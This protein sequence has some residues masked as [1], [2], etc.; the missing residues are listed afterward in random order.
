[1]G[2]RTKD[3]EL[4][5]G[6]TLSSSALEEL[7]RTFRGQLVTPADAEYDASRRVRNAMVDRHPALIA[8][9]LGA[10]DVASTI[11]FAREQR[12]EVAVR[13]GG[14]SIVGHS[15]IDGAVVIDLSLMRGVEIDVA[16]LRAR[17]QGGAMIADLDREAQHLGLATTG[18][19]VATTGVGGLTLG[20]G[21]GWLA[22]RFGM[23]CDNLRSAQ[24][25]T[26]DGSVL[27]AS[28]EEHPDLFWAIRGGGG[29]FG[30]VTSF[31]LELHRFGPM[32]A[33][34]DVFYRYEDG[35]AA[36]RAF[37]DLLVRAPDEL[38]LAASA[39]MADEDTP[40]PDEYR[41]RPIVN[42]TWTWVGD[43][44]R[45]GERIAQPLHRAP[46]PVAQFVNSMTYVQLQSGP[47]GLDRP[48]RR[49]YW[50]SSFLKD[51]SDELLRTFLEATVAANDGRNLTAGEMLSM[52]GAIGRVG[53]EE[54]AYA[55]R[56]ALVDFLAV[57]GWTDPAEDDDRMG[58]ARH[59][60]EGVAG[61]GAYGVYVNNLG[62]EGQDRVRE[63]YGAAKYAR[64]ATIKARYDSDNVFRHNSNIRPDA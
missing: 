37:R 53:E 31:E 57:A 35:L 18:G 22:R 24:V 28:E 1:M 42:L 6:V 41:G 30:V 46:K 60:W 3:P 62:S 25:V 40:V 9:C 63:A 48:R 33:S 10:A 4:V 39:A 32:V 11:A 54:T 59:V 61:L 14:H 55:H 23:A 13:G 64:L 43:R 2:L 56:E 38:Y 58:A 17:A 8:R 50:K 52:G 16:R 51:L 45:D 19:L 12:L 49:M 7:R 34:G 26:A 5:Q 21:Y 44:P 15:V 47:N 27:I 36:L 29:N 20:G